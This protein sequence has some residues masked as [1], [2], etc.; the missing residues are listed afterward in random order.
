MPRIRG[1]PPKT[2][3]IL[4]VRELVRQNLRYFVLAT[5]AALALRLFFL[6]KF[7][8][9]TD[10]SRVYADIAK[11]WLL[12]GV[13]S[14]TYDPG[15]IVPTD[16]RL[17]G[18]P[19]FLA[20]VFAIF[21]IENYRA[22][23]V[24]QVLVDIGTCFVVA[25]VARRSICDRAAKAA[26]LLT[27]LCPFLAQYAAAALTETLEI[28][29]TALA[30]DFAV[31]GLNSLGSEELRPWLQCGAAVAACI[32]LRPDGGLLL[33]ALGAY[34]GILMLRA[35]RSKQSLIPIMRAGLVLAAVALSPLAVWGARNVHTLHRWQFL[36]PRFANEGDEFVPLGFNRW[37]NT[38]IAD[39]TSTEEVYWNVPG[40]KVD[41]SNLPARAFDSLEQ[42]QK[43]LQLLEDYNNALN[44]SPLLDARFAA[45]A[46]ERIRAH[47]LRYYVILPALK[48][49]DM[50]LR[51]RT[52]MLPPSSRWYE[53]DDDRKWIVLAVGLGVLNL[54]YVAAAIAGLIRGRPI[55]W[56]GL[57]ISYIVLR[58][59]FL[60]TMQNPES[61]YTLECYPIVIWFAAALWRRS[62]D[63][64]V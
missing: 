20:L 26:F 44:I 30:L 43:T 47:P 40:E 15:Q 59:L 25:D 13:Y 46:E 16:S 11:N 48:I 19:A 22:V 50:W 23:L 34:S 24:I 21:G 29:F 60:G 27:G 31:I 14:R 51:P 64:R 2:S 28:F 53:F 42:K 38:W 12:K 52:E 39:Y 4:T 9:I 37:V 57:G 61:R 58:S 49:A 6:L 54:L 33:A 55:A 63:A 10:D 41:A 56:A 36:A 5:L 18:Y 62:R 45:L 35:L 32:L 17:P 3:Y 8:H 1:E 7:P